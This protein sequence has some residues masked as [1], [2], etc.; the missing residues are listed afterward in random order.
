MVLRIQ[1]YHNLVPVDLYQQTLKLSI[2]NLFKKSISFTRNKYRLKYEYYTAH[3][4]RIYCPVKFVSCLKQNKS[5]SRY[6]ISNE[7]QNNDTEAK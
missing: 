2:L 7:E 1:I 6:W 4:C 3:I 5:Q